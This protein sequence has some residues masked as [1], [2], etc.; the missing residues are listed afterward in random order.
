MIHSSHKTTIRIS[1]LQKIVSCHPNENCSGNDFPEQPP[2]PVRLRAILLS[3]INDT[4]FAFHR[5]QT[6]SFSYPV[7]S[8]LFPAQRHYQSRF[9]KVDFIQ[10]RAISCAFSICVCDIFFAT[11]SRLDSAFLSP[12]D[13]EIFHHI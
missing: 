11:L 5:V 7:A 10:S 13:A 4:Y 12:D 9:L 8:D 3:H 6:I 2:I 1:F